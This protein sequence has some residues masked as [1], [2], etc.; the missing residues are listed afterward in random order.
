ML[1]CEIIWKWKIGK[2]E[3]VYWKLRNLKINIFFKVNDIKIIL[4]KRN[5][6]NNKVNEFSKN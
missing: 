3:Y 1:D 4:E 6:M 5:K 2:V